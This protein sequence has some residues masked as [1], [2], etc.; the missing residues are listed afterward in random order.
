MKHDK[1]VK[2]IFSISLSI[3]LSSEA[4]REVLIATQ[5]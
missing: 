2:I 5:F 3:P 4:E 1:N